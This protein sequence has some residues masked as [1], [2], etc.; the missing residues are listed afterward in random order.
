MKTT[1]LALVCFL[2]FLS[3]GQDSL[4]SQKI[5][6]VSVSHTMKK[7]I[8][9]TDSKYFIIDFYIGEKGSF[10]LL[11]RFKKYYLYSLDYKMELEDEI[12]LNFKPTSLFEDCLGLVHVMSKDSMYQ[13]EKFDGQVVFYE[14]N[15]NSL[16][17][18][19]FKNCIGQNDSIVI[20]E[21]IVNY[22][23]TQ[24][25]YGIR[26]ADQK[27]FMLYRAE[28]S[29]L[30]KSALDE[31]RLIRA[32]RRGMP[33]LNEDALKAER[34]QAQRA[35]FFQQIVSLPEYNPLFVK[36]DTTYIFDHLKSQLT[37]MTDTGAVL[38]SIPIDYHQSRSWN[39]KVH[40]DKGRGKFYSVNEKNGAQIFCHL[41][42]ETFDVDR[43][44]K[45]YKHAYP[46]K[47]IVFNGF[48]YYTYKENFDDNLNKL[49]RQRI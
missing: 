7:E 42:P 15:S 2:T 27:R 12:E 38:K 28:D 13:V 3:F 43:S 6:E 19:F 36:N 21:T 18:K 26:M 10:L 47:I 33:T 29:L 11:N 30:V 45:V 8:A 44:T 39:K 49:F 9:F 16:Y 4:R 25:F 40:L 37:L 31:K 22:G 46:K 5:G 20:F 35:Q 1:L 24:L 23:K 41:N 32:P 34:Q 17:Q 48:V 14:R